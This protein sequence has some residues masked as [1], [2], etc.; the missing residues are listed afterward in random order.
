MLSRLVTE[1][2]IAGAGIGLRAVHYRQILERLPA[3]GW[4]EGH[5]ENYFGAGGQPLEFLERIRTRYP[6]SLHGVGLSLGSTDTLDQNH[7]LKL[8]ALC[9]RFEPGL[10]SEHLCWSS[11]GGRHLNDLLP[12]PFTEESLAHVVERI[13][14]V[15]EFL[16][17]QILVENVSSYLQFS[18]STIPEWE[19][20]AEVASRTGC[21][22]LL[23]V[24]NVYVNAHN[25]GF[26]PMTY[27]ESIPVD[28][29]KEIHLAGYEETSYGVLLDTHGSTVSGPVWEL[30]RRALYRFGAVPTLV[31]WDT[32]IPALDV[33]VGEAVKANVMLE[34]CHA[35]PA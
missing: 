11:V 18:A 3:V 31:E 12:I 26:D 20:V 5:S 9:E 34:E 16:G 24:N 17:R 14:Q 2:E 28:P 25:H 6:L 19:F 8:K 15:Q 13:A 27:L 4:V 23:D 29:V 22:L 21:G 32:D 33:L 30:Y 35:Q 1:T 10:V 7:L